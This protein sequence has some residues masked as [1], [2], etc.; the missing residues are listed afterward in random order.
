MRSRHVDPRISP[1][2]TRCGRSALCAYWRSTSATT[3]G[4]LQVEV[5]RRDDLQERRW[6]RSPAGERSDVSK[7]P[8]ERVHE[9]TTSRRVVTQAIAGNVYDDGAAAIRFPLCLDGN[10]CVAVFE[11]RG[12]LDLASEVMPL[13]D[14][15]RT[16]AVN[17]SGNSVAR[18]ISIGAGHPISPSLVLGGPHVA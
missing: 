1:L 16:M 10:P 2:T 8:G 5:P 7:A 15:P 3:G 12:E 4:R 14:P 17:C 13:T 9:I 18:N 11:G 6:R